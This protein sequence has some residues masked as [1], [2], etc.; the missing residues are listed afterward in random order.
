[1]NFSTEPKTLL[2]TKKT[3]GELSAAPYVL[4]ID[5]YKYPCPACRMTFPRAVRIFEEEF[6]ISIIVKVNYH[7]DYPVNKHEEALNAMVDEYTISQGTSFHKFGFCQTCTKKTEPLT[8]T[9]NNTPPS[10]LNGGSSTAGGRLEKQPYSSISRSGLTG[11]TDK[12]REDEFDPF[13]FCDDN[14]YNSDDEQT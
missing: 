7:A 13:A 11:I 9:P 6:D 4:I 2:G 5:T 8:G 14:V 1:M 3:E 10:K 12:D